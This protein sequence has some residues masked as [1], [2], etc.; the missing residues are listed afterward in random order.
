MDRFLHSLTPLH[1]ATLVVGFMM[2]AWSLFPQLTESTLESEIVAVPAD[3]TPAGEQPSDPPEARQPEAQAN[4]DDQNDHTTRRM[5]DP[6]ENFGTASFADGG[7]YEGE[8]DVNKPDGEGRRIWPDGRIY[9]GLWESGVQ[10]GAGVIT[11][12]NGDWVSGT[13]EQGRLHGVGTC[14][15]GGIEASCTF[16]KGE[17]LD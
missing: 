10:H 14:S 12:A 17:R 8:F 3:I 4:P 9:Q 7:L 16:F 13:F 2:L 11:Y 1:W 15:T 6:L 5:H